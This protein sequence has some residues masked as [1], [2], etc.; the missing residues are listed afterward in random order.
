MKGRVP[1]VEWL[2]LPY[3][4]LHFRP[5]PLGTDNT[6]CEGR[7]FEMSY[8]EMSFSVM[9]YFEMAYFQMP[10]FEMVYF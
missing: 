5:S 7:I 3:I 2:S 8:L 10:Y 1:F 9:T 6:Y 4:I